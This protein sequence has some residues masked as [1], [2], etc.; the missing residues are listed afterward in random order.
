[1]SISE[2]FLVNWLQDDEQSEGKFVCFPHLFVNCLFG[3]RLR[4]VRN[5]NDP[6]GQKL[7]TASPRGSR[8]PRAKKQQ[9][10]S[11]LCFLRSLSSFLLL[12]YLFRLEHAAANL[13]AL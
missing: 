3:L 5:N 7:P 6:S 2:D 1:M 10:A 9:G 8:L 4:A 11:P 13:P 12:V